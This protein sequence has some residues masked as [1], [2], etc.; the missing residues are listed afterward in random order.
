ML[1]D[2]NV[3]RDSVEVS[4]E[5]GEHTIKTEQKVML[6]IKQQRTGLNSEF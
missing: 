4:D 1:L 6:V 3:K 5:N 2:M